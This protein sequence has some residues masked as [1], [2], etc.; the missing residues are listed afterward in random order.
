MPELPVVPLQKS[1]LACNTGPGAGFTTISR[2]MDSY[3]VIDRSN[4]NYNRLYVNYTLITI[5]R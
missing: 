3:D 2:G 1:V 4:N 5:I